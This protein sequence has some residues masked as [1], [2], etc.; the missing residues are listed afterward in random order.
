MDL[1]IS[2]LQ[3]TSFAVTLVVPRPEHLP[4]TD[5]TDTDVIPPCGNLLSLARNDK[6]IG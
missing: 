3:R 6:R 4:R 2:V 1:R 5:P